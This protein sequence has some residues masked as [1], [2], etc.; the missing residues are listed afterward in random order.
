M[1]LPICDSPC[2]AE[3]HEMNGGRRL[4]IKEGARLLNFFFGLGQDA[5]IHRDVSSACLWNNS[6]M[7]SAASLACVWPAR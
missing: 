7:T 5:E 4:T 2:P 3:A 1:E 6:A